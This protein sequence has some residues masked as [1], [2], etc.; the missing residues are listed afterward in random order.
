MLDFIS[1]PLGSFLH[2]I[3]NN[4][5]FLSYGLS[6]IIF[7]FFIRIVLLPLTVKQYSSMVRMQEVQPQI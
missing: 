4:M 2:F 7:T 6:I 3:Y 1:Y 5:A